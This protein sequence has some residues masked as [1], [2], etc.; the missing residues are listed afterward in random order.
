MNL[1]WKGETALILMSKSMGA[2]A[3]KYF[4]QVN[5]GHRDLGGSGTPGHTD[6]EVDLK[7][8][9]RTL[10]GCRG[11]WQFWLRLHKTRCGTG[12]IGPEPY[13]NRCSQYRD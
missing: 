13:Q 7:F 11:N 6:V 3:H 10:K 4:G 2:N 1:L 12:K 5:V 9:Q 8:V